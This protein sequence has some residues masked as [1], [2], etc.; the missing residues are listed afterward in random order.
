[1]NYDD[2]EEFYDEYEDEETEEEETEVVN[3][4]DAPLLPTNEEA[5]EHSIKKWETI[6]KALN[7]GKKITNYHAKSCALCQR[8]IKSFHCG[9]CPV[10]LKSQTYGCQDTPWI[11]FSENPNY[12]NAIAE[13]EFL[14]SLRK[15]KPKT[16]NELLLEELK[17]K[18]INAKIDANNIVIDLTGILWCSSI[19][20][21][22]A[23]VKKHNA[24]MYIE[25]S[26]I[27]IHSV[28]EIIPGIK[29]GYQRVE[30]QTEKEILGKT[31]TTLDDTKIPFK[32]FFN[33]EK[34]EVKIVDDP[35]PEENHS[36]LEIYKDGKKLGYFHLST[37]R[38]KP[39][40][41]SFWKT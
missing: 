12:T 20:T 24:N 38:D 18:G 19:A 6:A 30:E 2:E 3:L 13:V 23:L 35:D 33:G 27:K 34:L 11:Q 25:D 40:W 28:Q 37:A 32:D 17:S 7:E 29:G 4:P 31:S 21:V 39:I 15:P 16:P 26:A 8:N 22:I 36:H 1:M 14:K 41:Q 10:A 9:D 5:L